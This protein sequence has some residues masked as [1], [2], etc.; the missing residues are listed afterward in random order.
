MRNAREAKTPKVSQRAMAQKL[1]VAHTTVQR[2]ENG[3]GEV[4][5]EDVAAYLAVLGVTGRQ[6]EQIL[7][8]ARDRAETDWL[9]SGPPGISTQLAGVM[10]CERTAQIV[11][12]Y[13]PL[14]V[15]GLLQ[16][17]RYAR[18]ILS[19]NKKLSSAEIDTQVTFRMGRRDM[20]TRSEPVQLLALLGEPAIRGGIGGPAVMAD[21]LRHLLDVGK[22]ENVTIR[23][24]S[25]AGEWNPGHAGQ[26][27]LYEST[28]EPK[29]A[30]FEHH[31][32]G[33]FVVDEGD[34]EAMQA[35][36]DEI[37]RVAMSPKDSMELIADA[38]TVMERTHG[39]GRP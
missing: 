22:R 21:Q 38:L 8:L 36:A 13:Q 9:V 15:P 17:S 5:V 37:C 2:W 20:I 12:M 34:V 33:A 31:R 29:I 30:Y 19:Q 27:V 11:T 10:E 3:D 1:G 32:T 26:F 14:T 24:V 28:I 18:A 7:E 16:T 23:V 39:N 6:A 4:S 35:A 25:L